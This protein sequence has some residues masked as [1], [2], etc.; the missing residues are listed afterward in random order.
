MCGIAAIIKNGAALDKQV[1]DHFTDAVAHRG[2]DSRGIACFDLNLNASGDNGYFNVGLGHRRLSIID[3]S[4][5][6][7]QPMSIRGGD[8]VITYNGEIY[9]YLEIR[10]ELE[11]DGFKF[12]SSC[13]TEVLLASY[14]KWGSACLGKLNGMWAFVILDRRRNIF[15]ASRDR[16]GIKPLYCW[17]SGESIAFASEIKQFFHLPAFRKCVNK[18]SLLLYLATGYENTPQSFYEGIIAFPPGH[19][20]EIPVARPS[21]DPVRYWTPPEPETNT[22]DEEEVVTSISESFSKSISLHLRSDVPVGVCFSGGLDSS[23]I[24]FSMGKLSGSSPIS[25][26]SACFNEDRFDERPFMEALLR[27]GD[28]IHEKVFPGE[29]D[30]IRHFESFLAQHDEPVGSISMFA[31]YMVMKKARDN[32]VPVLLDGQGGDELL[33]GYWS[34]YMLLLNSLAKNRPL[35]FLGHF[36]G[37]LTGSGNPMLFSESLK[38]LREFRKRSSTRFLPFNPK[39]EFRGLLESNKL[40]R[41]HLDAQKLSPAQ[42]RLAEIF[43]IHLPRLLKWE[44]INSMASSIESRIPFLDSNFL[45]LMLKIPPQMNMK[46]GWTK[47][48]FRKAM[49]ETLPPKVCWRKDKMGFDTPQEQWMKRGPLYAVLLDWTIEDEHPV[50]EYIETDFNRIRLQLEEENFDHNSIFRLFCAD[51]WLKQ[52]KN[53]AT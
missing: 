28:Y 34:S 21:L 30:F 2:P 36:A 33:S 1:M 18:E 37:A 47:Y 41:W 42:Y 46:S 40:S 13:D 52:S 3:L 19:F 20:A 11:N 39:K 53:E 31:Q 49:S 17:H 25:A 27:T 51:R 12:K 6:G 22:P 48:L 14:A 29:K 50:T 9:N 7:L 16:V 8:Y 44:D 15:F 5:A 26:F 43:R 23:S 38:S 24:L 10:K 45:E 32:G 4:D 35:G